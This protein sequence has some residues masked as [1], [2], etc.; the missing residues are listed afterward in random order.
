MVRE[1]NYEEVIF[2]GEPE[3]IAET[4]KLQ[5]LDLISSLKSVP[6]T[7]VVISPVIPSNIAKWNQ[8]RLS[9]GKTYILKHTEKYNKWQVQLQETVIIANKYITEINITNNLITPRIQRPVMMSRKLKAHQTKNSYK[10]SYILFSDGVHPNLHLKNKIA[11]ILAK[12]ITEN[13]NTI[14]HTSE[15]QPHTRSPQ[16]YRKRSSKNLDSDNEESST[17]RS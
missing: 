12:S 1:K 6:N 10:F 5:V 3:H 9:Q 4:L 13:Y 16:S 17:K 2:N 15:K 8:I 7:Y 11:E 14:K